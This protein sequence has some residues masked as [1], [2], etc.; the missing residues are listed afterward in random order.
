MEHFI[1]DGDPPVEFKFPGHFASWAS[2]TDES[3]TTIKTTTTTA[4]AAAATRGGG[5][6]VGGGAE[7]VNCVFLTPLE[8]DE[9]DGTDGTG[10]ARESG[11]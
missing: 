3:T 9:T 7:A 6:G 2:F 11:G 10:L 5:G 4:A 8:T 1:G